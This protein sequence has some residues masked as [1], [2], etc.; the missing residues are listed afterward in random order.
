MNHVRILD[1]GQHPG[2][3]GH[4]GRDPIGVINILKTADIFMTVSLPG[5]TTAQ[6]HR[7]GQTFD[8]IKVPPLA[9]HVVQWLF[10][11]KVQWRVIDMDGSV[12]EG[13]DP[14][15]FFLKHNRL[16]HRHD[17][18]NFGFGGPT[19][20]SGP[21]AS[22]FGTADRRPLS[23]QNGAFAVP[24][25]VSDRMDQIGCGSPP[26]KVPKTIPKPVP[27][28][29]QSSPIKMSDKL[30]DKRI[31]TPQPRKITVAGTGASLTKSIEVNQGQADVKSAET[32]LPIKEF[33]IKVPPK[34][35]C[36]DSFGYM[37]YGCFCMTKPND[38][39]NGSSSNGSKPNSY[40]PRSPTEIIDSLDIHAPDDDELLNETS[41]GG[42]SDPKVISSGSKTPSNTFLHQNVPSNTFLD[43]NNQG[44]INLDDIPLQPGDMVIA[45]PPILPPNP[46]GRRIPPLFR[47][48]V[49]IRRRPNDPAL[50]TATERRQIFMDSIRPVKYNSSMKGKEYEAVHEFEWKTCLG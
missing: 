41:K 25:A 30:S 17:N 26:P 27:P 2:A 33:E 38:T 40:D 48:E 9:V 49:Q 24:M 31:P 13:L 7:S 22:I 3:Y 36:M 42:G 32:T 21:S 44:N 5:V 50:S 11:L 16:R 46:P 8:V 23:S 47:W 1:L 15:Y 39:A 18:G 14:I 28:V 35:G 12:F 43:Q 10:D 20:I 19:S 29:R 34:C 6:C 4:G 37:P 45:F